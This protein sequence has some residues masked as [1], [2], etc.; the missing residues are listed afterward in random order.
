MSTSVVVF[1]HSMRRRW[2]VV[3]LLLFCSTSLGCY[4]DRLTYKGKLNVSMNLHECVK[5]SDVGYEWDH[6]YCL[7]REGSL[8][9][10]FIDVEGSWDYCYI[11]RVKTPICSTE[12]F[13]ER[14]LMPVKPLDRTILASWARDAVSNGS[15]LVSW[16]QLEDPSFDPCVNQL[17]H[18]VCDKGRVVAIV[19]SSIDCLINTPVPA[20]ICSL[21]ELSMI[22]LQAA[23]MSGPL[24]SFAPCKD[25]IF[26]MLDFNTFTG[27]VVFPEH[28]GYISFVGCNISGNVSSLTSLDL[29]ELYLHQNNF[30]SKVP[31][32]AFAKNLLYVTLSDNG[33]VC[34]MSLLLVV[35][36]CCCLIF[37]PFEFLAFTGPLPVSAMNK[38]LAQFVVSNNLFSGSIIVPPACLVFR[39]SKNRL[40]GALPDL[41]LLPVLREFVVRHN[42][43]TG[44]LPASLKMVTLDLSFNRLVGN[45][46]TLE[47]AG[48]VNLANNLFSGCIATFLQSNPEVFYRLFVAFFSCFSLV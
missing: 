44:T 23:N 16:G 14:R 24:P 48:N 28:A 37:R 9:W 31:S 46:S 43:L 30:V 11:G 18:I 34:C 13:D 8:P 40:S 29:I 1:L 47:V 4:P 32:L 42:L 7:L 19:C 25:L 2:K 17:Q 36:V 26:I 6:N 5:W 21:P 10:C 15:S 45:I 27:G 33:T 12:E 3:L 41:S 39:A 22:W 35:G 38:A 20:D